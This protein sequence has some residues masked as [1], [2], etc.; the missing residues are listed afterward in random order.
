MTDAP[1]PRSSSSAS[2][3]PAASQMA[4]ALL[5]HHAGDRVGRPLRGH[6]ARPTTSTRRSSRPWPSSAS[7]CA[8]RAPTRRGSRTP[9]SQASDVVITMGC[10]DAC[11]FYPGTRYEDWQLDDPAGQGVDA[12]RPIRDEIDRRVPGCSLA[13]LR[14]HRRRA[15]EGVRH[16]T[17]RRSTTS[18]STSS[19]WSCD[20]SAPDSQP[21]FAGTF[22]PETIERFVV[23]S[24]DQLLPTAK[25]TTFLPVLAER[26]AR[27]APPGPRPGRW[28]AALD[29]PRRAVPLRAQRR[30]L[31]DG[32]WLAPPPRRRHGSS[33]GPVGPS[34]PRRSTRR[35][36]RRWPRSAST[37]P[38]SSRNPGPTRSSRPPMWSSRWAAATPA[39]S[40]PGSGTRTGARRSRWPG[41]RRGPPDPRRD[42]RRVEALMSS[43]DLPLR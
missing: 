22:G 24:L 19:T 4:A 3:T 10:G 36:S 32:R 17:I 6:G 20:A 2:T 27:R 40:T 34:R 29:G 15:D 38:R 39:R 42:P 12:V 37:S 21:E 30:S 18:P 5:A 35:R 11:P 31:A 9:R 16:D 33:S 14:P 26:F 41:P 8:P 1:T 7:T 13:E 28:F 23:D 25:V 43:L